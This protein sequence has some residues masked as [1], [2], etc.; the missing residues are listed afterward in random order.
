MNSDAIKPMNIIKSFNVMFLLVSK[1]SPFNEF[2]FDRFTC[3]INDNAEIALT[4]Y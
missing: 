1:I 3:S 2:C 4:H